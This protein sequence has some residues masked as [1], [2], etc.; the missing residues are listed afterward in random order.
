MNNLYFLKEKL[1]KPLIIITNEFF[2][3]SG[4]LSGITQLLKSEDISNAEKQDIENLLI[5]ILPSITQRSIW[6][7]DELWKLRTFLH[8]LF[9]KYDIS[10]TIEPLQ[11]SE[12][13]PW[14]LLLL[15]DPNRSKVQ[16]YLEQGKTYLARLDNE[17][18]GVY[19]LLPLNDTEIELMNIAIA[20]S[21]QG[22]GLG[23]QLIINAIQEAKN[24]KYQKL[25]VGTGNSSISEIAFYQK[26][27]FQLHSLD[28]GFFLRNYPEAIFENGI[29]CVDMIRFELDL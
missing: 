19:V 22:K 11:N 7:K 8:N 14:H 24:L 27:G 9:E 6:F 5:D 25:K 29:Q 3:F 12:T 15:A 23:K 2:S 18:V 4:S 26:C 17:V 10:M 16:K 13:P 20:E 28:K 1:F 21:E